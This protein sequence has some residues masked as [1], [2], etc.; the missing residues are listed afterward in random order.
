MS[1]PLAGRPK[2]CSANQ[3][4]HLA[5]PS[6]FSTALHNFKTWS[7]TMSTIKKAASLPLDHPHKPSSASERIGHCDSWLANHRTTDSARIADG[8]E[9][10]GPVWCK[11]PNGR[12]FYLERDLQDWM[13]R[14]YI[15]AIPMSGS[16]DTPATSG[17]TGDHPSA[18]A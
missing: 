7:P 4:S 16:G 12:I 9:P 11:A 17:N 3:G 8:L 1:R 5:M 13:R 6:K 10:I 15:R 2:E 18:A 14:N